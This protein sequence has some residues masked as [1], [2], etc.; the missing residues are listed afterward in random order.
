MSFKDLRLTLYDVLG[1]FPPG[2]VLLLAVLIGAWALVSEGCHIDLRP[3]QS[4]KVLLAIL[5]VAY[6]LGHVA[7]VFANW[8]VRFNAERYLLGIQTGGRSK[9][10]QDWMA[11][12][13]FKIEPLPSTVR[14]SVTAALRRYYSNHLLDCADPKSYQACYRLCDAVL[15]ISEANEDREVFRSREGFYKGLV[16]S[17]LLVGL[18]IFLAYWMKSNACEA[19]GTILDLSLIHI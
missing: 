11:K 16:A 8:L 4:W 7:Q 10:F 18:T 13:L 5:F 19:T 3:L 17:L 14:D 9:K 6:V 15:S 12:R 1:Y 2:L